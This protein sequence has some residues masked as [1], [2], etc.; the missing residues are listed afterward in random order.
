MDVLG[1]CGTNVK[2]ILIASI[3]EVLSLDEMVGLVINKF[4]FIDEQRLILLVIE[5]ND[6][7]DFLRS[8]VFEYKFLRL[9]KLN[10]IFLVALID[11]SFLNV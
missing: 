8:R 4:D 10:L 11:L 6:I 1:D 5:I 2:D 7:D 9:N 3:M